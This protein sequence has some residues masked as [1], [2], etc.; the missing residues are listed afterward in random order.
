M[1]DIQPKKLSVK[2]ASLS[3]DRIP[4]SLILMY[5]ETPYIMKAGLEWKANQ[6]FGGAG[7]SLELDPIQQDWEKKIFV[8]KATLTVLKNGV[9][10]VN[11]GEADASNANS[12]MQKQ[13]FHLAATRAEC[14]VLRMATACGYASYEEVVLQ[15]DVKTGEAPKELEAQQD[16]QLKIKDEQVETIYSMEEK[17]GLDHRDTSGM[18]RGE[19]RAYIDE[20]LKMKAKKEDHGSKSAQ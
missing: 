18:T 8:F 11:F 12:Q 16:D 4:R 9:K 7:Y 13:L 10:Y 5:G 17:K 6:L 15:G 2:D 14:R 19:A 1:S 20:L 3:D